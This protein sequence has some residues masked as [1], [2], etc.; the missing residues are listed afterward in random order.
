MCAF[1]FEPVM[2]SDTLKN[3][4]RFLFELILHMC[5]TA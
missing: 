1:K 2:R 5:D 4:M 3:M